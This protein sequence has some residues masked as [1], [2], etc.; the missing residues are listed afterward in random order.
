MK[1]LIVAV[2]VSV[3]AFGASI[4]VELAIDTSINFN[5]GYW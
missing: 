5:A 3:A 2:L 1:V 4:A